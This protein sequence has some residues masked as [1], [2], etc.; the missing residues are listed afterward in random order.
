MPYRQQPHRN[1]H[2]AFRNG[3]VNNN[4]G[5]AFDSLARASLLTAEA[6]LIHNRAEL[7]RAQNTSRN[8]NANRGHRGRDRGRQDHPPAYDRYEPDDDDMPVSK[9]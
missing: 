9:R 4:R 3:Y 5:G 7:V 1:G 8:R 2:R 6:N